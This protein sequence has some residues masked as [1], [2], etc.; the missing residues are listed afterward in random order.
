M[1]DE[2]QVGL[3]LVVN[4]SFRVLEIVKN[5]NLAICSFRCNNFLILWHV[6]SFVDFALMVNLYIDRDSGLL[7]ISDTGAANSI[8]VV[9]QNILL[10][11]PCVFR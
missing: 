3:H 5:V 9:V 11:V 6:S 8:G 10:I 4:W 2:A 7:G 1:A